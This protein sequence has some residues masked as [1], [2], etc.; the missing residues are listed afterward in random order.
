MDERQYKRHSA[1]LKRELDLWIQAYLAFSSLGG[2]WEED[3]ASVLGWQNYKK[4][5]KLQT[6]RLPRPAGVLNLSAQHRGEPG[7][8]S[9]TR[10]NGLPDKC[11]NI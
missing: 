6:P 4:G 5:T 10:L 1:F 7:A 3:Q 8:I 2:R 11:V 9:G